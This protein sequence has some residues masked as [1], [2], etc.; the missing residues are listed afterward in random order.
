MLLRSLIIPALF[1][2]LVMAQTLPLAGREEVGTRLRAGADTVRASADTVREYRGVYEAGFEVSWF[3][4]CDATPGDDTW[5]VTL[6]NDALH[7]RDSLARTLRGRPRAVLVRWRATVGPKMPAGA[8]H[9][10]RGSRYMLV[11]RVLSLSPADS[12][13][14]TSV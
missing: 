12:A 5:W 3:H 4:P 7:Q 14:C 8:G 6:T 1:G 2:R 9:M 10:G 11:T 13:G